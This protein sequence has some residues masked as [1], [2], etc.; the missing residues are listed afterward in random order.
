MTEIV[1]FET[2][3]DL[4]QISQKQIALKTIDLL[5]QM[6]ESLGGSFCASGG[7]GQLKQL[8]LQK[9]QDQELKQLYQEIKNIFDPNNILNCQVKQTVSIRQIAGKINHYEQKYY[10]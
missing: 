9:Q 7:A 8:V 10:N 2:S 6:T 5:R 1:D 4:T 3:F